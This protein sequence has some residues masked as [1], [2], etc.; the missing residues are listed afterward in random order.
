MLHKVTVL[1]KRFNGDDAKAEGIVDASCSE[2]EVIDT[3]KSMVKSYL[4][5]NGYN[6]NSL[7]K[8][9]CDLYKDVQVAFNRISKL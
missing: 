8:M 7:N 4:G 3:A 2:S 1:G 5:R 9:K 6:R